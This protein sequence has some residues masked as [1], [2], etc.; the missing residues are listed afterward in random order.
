MIAGVVTAA[1]AAGFMVAPAASAATPA[2][3]KKYCRNQG[4]VV[5]MRTAAFGTNSPP[6]IT[7]GNPTA[8]CFFRTGSGMTAT[9]IIVDLRTLT[10][11]KP[12]LAALAYLTKPEPGRFNPGANPASVYCTKLGGTDLFGGVNVSGGGWILGRSANS[13]IDACTFPDG[14]IIDSFGILY[15]SQGA[16][17]GADLTNKFRYR[18]ANPPNLFG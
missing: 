18:P 5:Q 9:Q 12:T 11:K 15:H 17:R 6:L 10:T 13:A 3:W 1:V 2:V 16:I 8:F 7:L 14:S 4:G